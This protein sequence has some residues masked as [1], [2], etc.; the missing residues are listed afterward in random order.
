MN[1][2]A[3]FVLATFL[4][5]SCTKVSDYVA[6]IVGGNEKKEEEMRKV[7]SMCPSDKPNPQIVEGHCEGDW[8]FSYDSQD[9]IYTCSYTHKTT[10]TCPAGTVSIGQPSACG[11]QL[12]QY[13]LKKIT[14]NDKCD[15]LFKDKVQVSYRLVCCT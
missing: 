15:D 11:G 12:E 13:T 2:I 5:T 6:S 14:N 10:I 8:S 7:P 9:K 4:T 1:K 3:V